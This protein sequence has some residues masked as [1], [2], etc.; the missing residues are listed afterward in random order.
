MSASSELAFRIRFLP[1]TRHVSRFTIL[2][3]SL[4]CFG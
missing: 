1:V 4:R 2:W 3:D